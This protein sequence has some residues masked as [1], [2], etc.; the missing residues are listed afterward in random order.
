MD[1]TQLTKDEKT[2]LLAARRE[3]DTW[4]EGLTPVVLHL[5]SLRVA[6]GGR[7]SDRVLALSVL[8]SKRFN[9]VGEWGEW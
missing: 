1:S 8:G 2:R 5:Q 3:S 4:R 9:E 7:I 6:V